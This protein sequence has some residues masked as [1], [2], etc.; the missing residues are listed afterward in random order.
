MTHF[1]LEINRDKSGTGRRPIAT[2]LQNVTRLLT[3]GQKQQQRNNQQRLAIKQSVETSLQQKN[4]PKASSAQ[5]PKVR[6][7]IFCLGVWLQYCAV[8]SLQEALEATNDQSLASKGPRGEGH[9]QSSSCTRGFVRT[10]AHRPNQTSVL[11]K[12]KRYVCSAIA[13]GRFD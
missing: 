8:L 2:G 6:W 1:G 13:P 7:R 5:A 9:T 10:K 11:L 12:S 3:G 4:V